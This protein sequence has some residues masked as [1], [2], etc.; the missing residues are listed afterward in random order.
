MNRSYDGYE[1]SYYWATEECPNVI[2]GSFYMKD[3]VDGTVLER[4]VQTAIRRFPYFQISLIRDGEDL[5]QVKDD[6]P[7]TVRRW[8]GPALLGSEET[9]GHVLM[10]SY[11]EKQIIFEVSHYLTDG[12]GFSPFVRSVLYYYL[13]GYYGRTFKAD[14]IYLTETPFFPGELGDP[15]ADVDFRTVEPPLYHYKKGELLVPDDIEIEVGQGNTVYYVDIDEERFMEHAK[16]NGA[17]PSSMFSLLLMRTFRRLCPQSGKKIVCGIGTNQKAVMGV[18]YN[19]RMGSSRVY[20]D[21]PKETESWDD[22]RL[23]VVTRGSI[24]LQNQ[25]ENVLEH[26]KLMRGLDAKTKLIP[27]LK[28]RCVRSGIRKYAMPVS[29]TYDVSYVGRMDWGEMDPYITGIYSEVNFLTGN[30]ML[31]EIN[32]IHGKLC[33][34]LM[35]GFE[36]GKVIHELLHILKE[37][38]IPAQIVLK[39]A[40]STSVMNV[41]NI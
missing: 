24:L 41:M 27:T 15:Y 11:E 17:S 4:A 37:M 12:A 40:M 10:V 30:M 36:D 23:S 9:N 3:E 5:I 39:K 7:I 22:E 34:A 21:Y 1:P 32:A 18:R 28:E 25:P 20:V 29:S 38:D 14:G 35:Q 16:K 6:R 19:Y 8:Q 26:E 13:C 2:F 33:I 31:A